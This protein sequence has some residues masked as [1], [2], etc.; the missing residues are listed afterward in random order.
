MELEFCILATSF[1]A[2]K[3]IFDFVRLSL[4]KQGLRY[5]SY[6][7]QDIPLC[8]IFY[9]VVWESL[10]QGSPFSFSTS[11]CSSRTSGESEVHFWC[12]L[13]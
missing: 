7:E 3:G 9:I 11:T 4:D 13:F 12:S 5:R 6:L 1:G 10:A 8:T 2:R